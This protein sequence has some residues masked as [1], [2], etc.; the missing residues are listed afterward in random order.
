MNINNYTFFSYQ[1]DESLHLSS[2]EKTKVIECLNQVEQ[3]LQH[4]IDKYSKRLISRSIEL[5]LDYCS[6]FNERQFITRCEVNKRIMN[7]TE[8]L[9]DEY[10]QSG[11][12]KSGILPLSKYCSGMLCL[13]SSYFND[14]LKFETGKTIEEYVQM[15]RVE[16]TKIRLTNLPT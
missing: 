10:I 11:K 16:V 3:E 7:K 2:R 5:L 12:L 9:L 1:V 15:K 13:S 6:R 4:A 14:L 8:L